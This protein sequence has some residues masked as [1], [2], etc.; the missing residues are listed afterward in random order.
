MSDVKEKSHFEYINF[1]LLAQHVILREFHQVSKY[2]VF[3]RD[4]C[5]KQGK[6]PE[7]GMG[8]QANVRKQLFWNGRFSL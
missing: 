2:T 8:A 6:F 3:A 7:I 5:R 1:K 4:K